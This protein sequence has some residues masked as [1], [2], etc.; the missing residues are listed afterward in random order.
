M[1]LISKYSDINRNLLVLG[2]GVLKPLK[3]RD[4]QIEK[5]FQECK[6]SQNLELNQFLNIVTFLWIL[7][8]VSLDRNILSLK[9]TK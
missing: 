9:K 1:S 5:L 8:L 4:Y 7:G 3:K 6:N 2:A